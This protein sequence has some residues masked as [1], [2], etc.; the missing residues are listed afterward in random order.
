[1]TTC[2]VANNQCVLFSKKIER[3]IK[4]IKNAGTLSIITVRAIFLA[5]IMSALGL[6]FLSGVRRT[7][8]KCGGSCSSIDCIDI[9]KVQSVRDRLITMS[10]TISQLAVVNFFTGKLVERMLTNWDDLVEDMAI[11]TDPEFRELINQVAEKIA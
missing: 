2:A 11:A 10:D 6:Y 3:S 1:M 4:T 8:E 9:E 5:L 7:F